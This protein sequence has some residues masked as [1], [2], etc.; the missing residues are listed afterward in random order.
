MSLKQNN[1]LY[2]LTLPVDYFCIAFLYLFSTYS[3]TIKLH[4][5]CSWDNKN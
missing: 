2:F 1:Y 4:W 5:G 3:Q